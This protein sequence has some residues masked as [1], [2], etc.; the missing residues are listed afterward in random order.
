MRTMP[1]QPPSS[2]LTRTWRGSIRA[3]RYEAGERTRFAVEVE[4]I[5]FFDPATGLAIWD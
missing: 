2:A 5:E 1:S 3:G 4:R